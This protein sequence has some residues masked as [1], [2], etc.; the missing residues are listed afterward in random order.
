MSST[1]RVRIEEG[2]DVLSD[3][4]D[5]KESGAVVVIDLDTD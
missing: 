5:L 1:E 2:N 3:I 4:L